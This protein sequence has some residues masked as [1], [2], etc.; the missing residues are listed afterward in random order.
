MDNVKN[1]QELYDA[2]RDEVAKGALYVTDMREGEYIKTKHKP[3]KY[4]LAHDFDVLKSIISFR[5][6]L[7]I[8]SDGLMY[9]KLY[10]FPENSLEV[11]LYKKTRF[12][13]SIV[14]DCKIDASMRWA[15]HHI[16]SLSEFVNM[17]GDL[18]RLFA[19]PFASY[20]TTLIQKPLRFEVKMG[21]DRVE[22]KD[23]VANMSFV[24]TG[25][26]SD[27]SGDIQCYPSLPFSDK[28]VECLLT[29]VKKTERTK[30]EERDKRD[31]QILTDLYMSTYVK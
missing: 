1:I 29:Y 16:V 24:I 7:H 8:L 3:A 28:E 18:G 11:R 4:V 21:V 14:P 20:F 13:K 10:P 9:V 5:H 6:S 12:K 30:K 17:G 15:S 22:I 25:I 23:E 31:K 2:M 19:E 27:Q 26:D